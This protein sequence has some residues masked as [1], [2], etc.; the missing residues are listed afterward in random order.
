MSDVLFQL[1]QFLQSP[2]LDIEEKRNSVVVVN[3]DQGFLLEDVVERDEDFSDEDFDYGHAP[4]ID[5]G[6]PSVRH[7]RPRTRDWLDKVYTQMERNNY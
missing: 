3:V 5:I 7:S 2:D 6:R 4:E 1:V